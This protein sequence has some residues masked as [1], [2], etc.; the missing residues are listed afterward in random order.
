MSTFLLLDPKTAIA[1]P[2]VPDINGKGSGD[3]DLNQRS[4]VVKM[5]YFC[6]FSINLVNTW[7]GLNKWGVLELK[8]C[9]FTTNSPLLWA[10]LPLHVF[11]HGSK[12]MTRTNNPPRE[13]QY[14]WH[15]ILHQIPTLTPLG[16]VRLVSHK[17][18][19]MFEHHR[20]CNADPPCGLEA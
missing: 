19:R 10:S 13:A 11:C 7:L 20:I 6:E 18:R 1:A 14:A 3:N 5:S 15:F 8:S 2:G 17:Y 9:H 12:K 4:I 16:N